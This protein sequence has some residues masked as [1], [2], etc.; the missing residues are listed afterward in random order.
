MVSTR[1]TG[2]LHDFVERDSSEYNFEL[3]KKEKKKLAGAYK[4]SKAMEAE[5]KALKVQEKL[6]EEQYRQSP[7]FKKKVEK[8]N[9]ELNE[10]EDNEALWIEENLIPVETSNTSKQKKKTFWQKLFRR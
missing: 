5:R 1:K 9:K 8:L 2:G 7:E 10:P 3:S 4:E 6:A